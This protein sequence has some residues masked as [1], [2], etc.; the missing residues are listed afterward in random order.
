VRLLA[1]RLDLDHV[2]P[3]STV[4]AVSTGNPRYRRGRV[5]TLRAISGHRDVYP[6]ECP[7]NRLYADLHAIA[8]DVAATGLP[9]IYS[10]VVSGA[11]GAEVRFRARIS[12][13]LPW[14]VTVTDA[15]SRVVATGFG[16]GPSV[17]WTWDATGAQGR[18][19]YTIDA[20]PDARPVVGFLGGPV[21]QLKIDDVVASPAVVSPNGDGHGDT[22]RIGYRLGAPATVTATLTDAAGTALG[23]LFTGQR[24]AGRHSFVWKDVGVVDGRYR[25]VLSAKG[26]GGAEV[27][28][29]VELAVDRTLARFRVGPRAISPNG[30]GRADFAS[31]VFD[32]LGPAQVRVELLRAG[33][34]VATV[35]RGPL[36]TGRQ[37]ATWDGRARGA[38]VPDGVYVA[39]VTA[40]DAVATVAQRI[41]IRVDTKR[42]ALRLLST[43]PLRFWVSEPGTLEVEID[44]EQV[45]QPVRRGSVTIDHAPPATELRA[46]AIDLAQNRSN[47]VRRP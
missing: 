36:Q 18:Y 23:V 8:R 19:A 39:V 45:V 46:V 30:D 47:V 42:P 40:V 25:I 32:L 27:S 6:T 14:T 44:G 11:L 41:S 22:A 17:D 37:H 38:R 21:A 24:G 3:L 26:S 10:P 12:A 28:R 5:V 35:L 15:A 20:G 16:T 31:L 34:S 1:W 43:S 2:D 7:G 4:T 29:A 33:R 13:P 9:K